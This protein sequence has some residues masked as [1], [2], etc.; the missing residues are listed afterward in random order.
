MSNH[1]REFKKLLLYLPFVFTSARAFAQTYYTSI[2]T[3]GE[4]EGF[5]ITEGI[6]SMNQDR[7][8]FIWISTRNGLYRFNGTSFKHFK[9]VAS[10][11][12]SL[13]ANQVNFCFQDKDG[14]YWV[15]I[16]NVGL[17]RYDDKTEH[18][19][20]WKNKNADEIDMSHLYNV[21]AP[22]EDSHGQLWVSAATRGIVRINK[23]QE[24]VKLFNV[25]DH[26]NAVDLY[27][28]CLWVHHFS[29]E[30]DGWFWLCSNDG[31]IHFNPFNGNFEVYRNG[32]EFTNYL[33][34]REGQRW[35]ATWGEGLKKFDPTSNKWEKYTWTNAGPQGTRN[36]VVEIL[37]KDKDHL[38]ISSPDNG[39]MIFNKK[40]GHFTRVHSQN[41]NDD[42]L[43]N[44]DKLIFDRNG[45]L[46]LIAKD[47]LA[48]IN[49]NKLFQ[50]EY[51]GNDKDEKVIASFLHMPGDS[52]VFVGSIYSK[53]GL[54]VYNQKTRKISVIPLRL[55]SQSEDVKDF[56]VDSKKQIWIS[57]SK[58]VFQFDRQTLLAKKFSPPPN[59][60]QKFFESSFEKTLEDR[61]HRLW[62]ASRWW[63]LFLY[64]PLK[65]TIIHYSSDSSLPHHIPFNQ[66]HYASFDNNQNL[67]LSMHA[68]LLEQPPAFCITSSGQVISYLKKI[69]LDI[70]P[71]V[72]TMKN[73]SIMVVT[74]LSGIFEISNALKTNETIKRYSEDNG[75]AHT[76][77]EGA[78][79][80]KKGNIWVTTHNG[81]SCLTPKGI[82]N[83]QMADGLADNFLQA[84]PYCDD[85]NNIFLP[86]KNGFQ[87]FNADSL[88]QYHQPIGPVMLESLLVNQKSVENNP[89]NIQ[90][91]NLRYNENN[92]S[93][94]F[95]AFDLSQG[96]KLQYAYQLQASDTT[97]N[98]LGNN[99]QLFFSNL[100]SGKYKL[101][102]RAGDRFGNWSNQEF[103][104][105]INIHPPFWKTWWFYSLCIVAT[106]AVIYSVYRM[107]V[108]RIV[109]EQR[110]RNKI[111]RDLHDDIG[112]TLS[113]IKLFSN[114]AQTKLV[115]EKSDALNIVERIGER[116]EKMIDA[117]S[118]IVWSINPANDSI[119]NMMVRMK[120]YAA[121]MLE[122]KDI[123]YRFVA[124][125]KLSKTKLSLETRKD[126]YL[127]FKESINNAV[128][129]SHC[130]NVQVALNIHRNLFEMIIA[131]DGI[132]F[133]NTN[134]N[135]Q[136]NGL[137]NFK[138]RA[139]R[140]GGQISIESVPQ[141]GTSIKLSLSLT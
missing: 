139:K 129:H 140:M 24:T 132:G 74:N 114:M 32:K 83:F 120:Q 52:L 135:G 88:L 46:W 126:V 34:D 31:M 5:N 85:D 90:S 28:S 134:N 42:I 79:E 92:L 47:Q 125:E 69:P 130:H 113:G 81:L 9:H 100:S 94:S 26:Y 36:I 108:N 49:G 72:I 1:L 95:A 38:W 87:F 118:D 136:G 21:I 23:T 133:D 56:F 80:D 104:L 48:R 89:N 102:L 10:D 123:S 141:K 59:T 43:S 18:F 76:Y 105:P 60:Y 84:P 41:K 111:A 30:Q 14:D 97:W 8:G 121:E 71:Q 39:L 110:L 63:G 45:N 20:Q 68:Y 101:K 96:D 54:H 40:D 131:D 55:H 33:K 86:F 6:S 99:R 103:I 75:I 122:P 17:Y 50:Y 12:F 2:K 65:K 98:N 27:R 137:I 22:F 107:R 70:A 106:L 82:I 57:T 51:I 112:S 67:W 29:E 73:N 64:D 37:E 138:E 91:L 16:A 19:T 35:V 11:S 109:A 127:V 61:Q 25:C 4:A 78:A 62:F 58:G 7:K 15:G 115:E 119:E 117:M 124:D 93:F 66:F 3:F 128:K 116:S 44:A 53:E 13:P 77:I